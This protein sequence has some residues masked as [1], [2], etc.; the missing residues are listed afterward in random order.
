MTGQ[1]IHVTHSLNILQEL[2]RQD[3]IVNPW[4]RLYYG[5]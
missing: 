5:M 3:G 4:R 2:A 1:D